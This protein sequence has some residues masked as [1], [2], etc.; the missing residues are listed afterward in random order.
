MKPPSITATAGT[1]PNTPSY[2]ASSSSL[3]HP[4]LTLFASSTPPP[5]LTLPLFFA[6]DTGVFPFPLAQ[7]FFTS[8]RYALRFNLPVLFDSTPDEES[9]LARGRGVFSVATGELHRIVDASGVRLSR[10]M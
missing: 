9:V 5:R 2:K 8:F 6:C 1:A 7:L 3:S 4:T 10:L